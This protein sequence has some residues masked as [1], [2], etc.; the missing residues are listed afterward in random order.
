M[1][2]SII[3]IV[4]SFCSLYSLAQAPKEEARQNDDYLQVVNKRSEKIVSTVGITD[5][6][7]FVKVR[8]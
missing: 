2:F 8:N 6:S 3:A 4:L 7:K 5:S 1:K